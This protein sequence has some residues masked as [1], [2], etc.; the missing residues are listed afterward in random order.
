M[1]ID[2]ERKAKLEVE[3][4][5]IVGTLLKD[6]S[7]ERIIL[8]GS[9]VTGRTNTWSD[10]DLVVVKSTKKRFTERLREVALM[11]QPKVGVDFFVYTPE[12]FSEMS[13][14]AN[15]FQR[16]EMLEKGKVLYDRS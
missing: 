5:R 4:Q 7:P 13:R 2:L 15:T 10:I 8:F 9:L 1:D 14:E 6:Y 11:T 12:E 3:L 16:R